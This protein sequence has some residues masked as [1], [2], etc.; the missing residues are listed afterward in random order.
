MTHLV[1][2][3]P[4]L[5]PAGRAWIDEVRARH[6]GELASIVAPHFT[7]VFPHVAPDLG[8]LVDH[9]R[10]CAGAVA[11]IRF[12][13]RCAFA[14]P[15][16][17]GRASL[18]LVPDEGFSS[19]VRLHDAL[20]TGLLAGELRHDLPFVPH[21]TVGVTELP[22]RAVTDAL[23]RELDTIAGS[24]DALDIVARMA[25]VTTVE[26]IALRDP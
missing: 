21:L 17:D 6:H 14:M 19:I 7:L 16:P 20:Y 2:A 3:Y 26:R 18:F 4:T 8:A 9:V 1:I 22:A 10:R 15:E 11:R 13:L 23:N 25:T 24:I 12:V 5:P